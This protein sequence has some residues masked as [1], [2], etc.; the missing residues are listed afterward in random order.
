MWVGSQRQA[1]RRLPFFVKKM[2]YLWMI[3]VLVLYVQVS[4]MAAPKNTVTTESL[5]LEMIDRD[6]PARYPD[7]YYSCRQS[8]S[9][10]RADAR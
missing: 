1:S 5:L 7:P 6:V 3:G 2:K 10:D 9:Y 8:S 4:A